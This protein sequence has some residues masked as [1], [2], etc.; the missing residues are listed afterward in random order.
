MTGWFKAGA[1]VVGSLAALVLVGSAS[2]SIAAAQSVHREIISPGPSTDIGLLAGAVLKP[3]PPPPRGKASNACR[4]R[5]REAEGPLRGQ[6]N[7][8][9]ATEEQLMALPG[10]GATKARRILEWRKR[11]GRFRR[12]LDLRRVRGF[13]R[14]NVARLSRYLTLDQPTTLRR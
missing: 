2:W 13:G 3:P 11:R 5:P 1:H 10:I 9:T 6:V 7:L 8:N 12:I 14:K 4:K